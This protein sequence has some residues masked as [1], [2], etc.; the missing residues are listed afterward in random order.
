MNKYLDISP[1]VKAALEAGKPV[2]ALESTIISHGMPYPKNVETALLVEQ[3]L[4]DNGA[5]PATIAVIGGRLKAGLSKEEIEKAKAD[6]EAYAA[7]DENKLELVN[8]KNAAD[9]QCF[10]IEKAFRDA[11]NKLTADD[12]KQV[13][14]EIA[15][16]KEAIK[17]DDVAKIDAAVEALN[18][19]YE[20]IVKKLYPQGQTANGQPQFTKEQMEEMMKNPQ[21]QQMFGQNGMNAD[22]WKNFAKNASDKNDDGAVDAEFC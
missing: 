8:K 18:K 12:K 4:R 7:E 2:V 6:A 14:D 22:A 11:G 3:T 16:V 19:A 1:E 13:E 5:V 15:K 9:G 17:T 10:A 21:F 20:P